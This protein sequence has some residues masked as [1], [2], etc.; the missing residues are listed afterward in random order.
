M[1]RFPLLSIIIVTLNSERT[2]EDCLLYI[3][4]QNYPKISEVIIV[5]GG[6][7]DKTL[8]ISKKSGL[9]IKII[10]GFSTS[11]LKRLQI[12]TLFFLFPSI[13]LTDILTAGKYFIDTQVLSA[14]TS[15]VKRQYLSNIS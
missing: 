7:T 15:A 12:A 11:K 5:D 8:E 4:K 10:K 2:I 13:I 14:Y 3:K 9:P 6:S 1:K